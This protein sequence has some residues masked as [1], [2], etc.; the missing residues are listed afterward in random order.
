MPIPTSTFSEMPS[1]SN[2]LPP[3][4]VTES[5]LS[6]SSAA[7]TSAASN[8]TKTKTEAKEAAD[9]LYEENIQLEMEKREGG[10]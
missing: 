1:N 2:T 8:N 5:E 7:Q 9:R 3:N 4:P 6:T 10:C